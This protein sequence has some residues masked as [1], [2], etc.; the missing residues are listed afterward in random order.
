MFAA[1][2]SA[3]SSDDP[4]SGL[5]LGD[6]PEPALPERWVRVQVRAGSRSLH[7]RWALRGVGLREEAL[8]MSLGCDAAAIDEDGNE[9]D[10]RSVISSPD[11]TGDETLDPKRSLLSEK[12]PGTF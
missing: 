7:E 9:V 1:Y 12:H 10:V 8:A 11:W 6:L 5:V 3:F 2:A 4:L